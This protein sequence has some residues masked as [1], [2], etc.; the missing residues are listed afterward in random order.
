MFSITLQ[1]SPSAQTAAPSDLIEE[2]ASAPRETSAMEMIMSVAKTA[3]VVT[4][5]EKLAA[6]KQ[7]ETI[8]PSADDP[9]EKNHPLALQ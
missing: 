3:L 1:A 8:T 5:E 7:G 9:F 2:P 6:L 4:I